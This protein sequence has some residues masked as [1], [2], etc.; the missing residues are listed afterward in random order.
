MS[1]SVRTP[2]GRDCILTVGR[3]PQVRR[4]G[5]VDADTA[6]K[7]NRIVNNIIYI[8]GLVVIIAAVLGYFG[9]R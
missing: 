5:R 1:V 8:V 7:E 6:T 3:D 4:T 2:G 9:F